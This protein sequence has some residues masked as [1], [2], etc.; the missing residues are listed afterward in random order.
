MHA[1]LFFGMLARLPGLLKRPVVAAYWLLMPRVRAVSAEYFRHLHA[2]DGSCPA[3]GPWQS[4][5]H[6]F[7][8]ADTIL[9]K[10]L[11]AAGRFRKG[12]IDIEGAEGLN[13]DR[14]G[15]ILVTAHTGCPEIGRALV[16]QFTGRNIRIMVH[17]KHARAFKAILERLHPGFDRNCIEVTEIT[18]AVAQELQKSVQAGDF[19][20]I[21]G[22]RTPIASAAQTAVSFLGEAAQLPTGA[23]IL[24]AILQVPVWSMLITRSRGQGRYLFSFA[25]LWEPQPVRRSERGRLFAEMA[26]RYAAQLEKAVVRSP[27]DWFNFYDFWDK[28]Q[29]K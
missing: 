15:A 6:V 19:I 25:R 9:D 13:A 20:V 24:G 4:L 29:A 16:D 26:V 21:V 10:L 27:Y 3:P 17:T 5:R 1:R 23:Y 7:R 2:F 11:A 8:F 12:D 28:E 14:R 18:P 22:D